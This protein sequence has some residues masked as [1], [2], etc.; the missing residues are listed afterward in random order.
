MLSVNNLSVRRGGKDVLHDVSLSV[1]AGELV[2]LVGP[3]GV[4]KSTLAMTLLGHPSCQVMSGSMTLDGVDLTSLKTHER[5]R[6]GL[7]LAHQEPPVIP[8]V[9]VANALRAASDAVRPTPYTT[10]EFFDHLRAALSRLG[11]SD[12]FAKR[13]LH[14]AFSGGEKKRSEL[15]ALLVISPKYA[16]LDEIDSGMDA[17]AKAL[18]KDVLAEL[19]TNGTGFLVISHNEP[20]IEELQPT[21]TLLFGS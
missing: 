18:T 3:N 9:S 5:A 16:I 10:A 21:R 8:G 17:V 14:E 7:F 6:H 19:R 15:L 20:F 1:D 13:N 2:A 11:L 4:G 12:D